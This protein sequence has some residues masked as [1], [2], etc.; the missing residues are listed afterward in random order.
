LYFA[1][2]PF[3]FLLEDRSESPIKGGLKA[4]VNP[5][6]VITA[7]AEHVEALRAD[8]IE[9]RDFERVV[10]VRDGVRQM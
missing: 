7:E 2:V 3:N 6:Q 8:R 4:R 1:C 10:G 5:K 9:S